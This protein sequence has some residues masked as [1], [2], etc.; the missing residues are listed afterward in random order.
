MFMRFATLATAIT[1]ALPA[2]AQERDIDQL[3]EL[4]MLPEIVDIMREEGASYGE[5][6]GQDL[7]A[8]EPSAEWS[9][10]VDTIY[11]YDVMVALVREDFGTSLE[12]GDLAPM[13]EFFGSEQGQKIVGLEVSGRRALLDDAVEEASKEA[14]LIAQDQMDARYLLVGE[15]IETNNLIETNVAGALNSNLAFFNGLVAGNAFQGALTEEQILTDVWGQEAEIRDSTS[16]W[17]YSFL[18][19]AYAPLDDADLQAY[20]AFS[21][22]EAGEH[23][24]RAMFESFDRLFTQISW[25]LGRAAANEMTSQEL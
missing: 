15:F 13:I 21:E 20:I 6:I 19:M 22:T 14:A 18:Y 8:G 5:T 24:N 17:I 23:I 11:N 2:T 12:G 25:S 10:T 3:F 4:L 9:A 16:E 1:F 7:F